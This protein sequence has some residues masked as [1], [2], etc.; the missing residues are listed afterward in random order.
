MFYHAGILGK[1]GPLGTVWI[2]GHSSKKVSKKKILSTKILVVC[3]DLET[4][5]G[6]FAL[7]VRASLL[8]GAT[9]ILQRQTTYL[10]HDA[11]DLRKKMANARS[12]KAHVINMK[13]KPKEK[14]KAVLTM[15]GA[16]ALS[17][18]ADW[19]HNAMFEEVMEEIEQDDLHTL[20]QNNMARPEDITLP[21]AI[22]V[23]DPIMEKFLEDQGKGPAFDEF[24][25]AYVDPFADDELDKL[26]KDAEQTLPDQS[27][28]LGGSNLDIPVDVP[29]QDLPAPVVIRQD[30]PGEKERGPEV[31]QAEGQQQPEVNVEDLTRHQ[32]GAMQ[33]PANRG[34]G[35]RGGRRRGPIVDLKTQISKDQMKLQLADKFIG[36]K[37]RE[38]PRQ[39]I[40]K[41]QQAH[42]EKLVY[43]TG[44]TSYGKFLQDVKH[45][46]F[47]DSAQVFKDLDRLSLEDDEDPFGWCAP[48]AP[49][50]DVP[51]NARAVLAPGVEP[52][53]VKSPERT[54]R[55]TEKRRTGGTTN[56]L[57]V[58]QLE[59]SADEP[60]FHQAN[61]TVGSEQPAAP[62]AV[63]QVSEEEVQEPAAKR[64]RRELRPDEKVEKLLE[65]ADYFE[66]RFEKFK[67]ATEVEE[68]SFEKIMDGNSR[69][70][71]ARCFTFMLQ[72]VKDGRIRVRQDAPYAPIMI[73]KIDPNMSLADP[74][75]LSRSGYQ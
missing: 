64:R 30:V 40:A 41:A 69:K 2:V 68:V 36:T 4:H 21:G 11:Q 14:M 6:K 53:A 73:Q 19:D 60:S 47:K 16:N 23:I 58:P 42:R 48:A 18:T 9:I 34:R 61:V 51:R 71:V 12:A 5:I 45:R 28:G 43:T 32:P 29:P 15:K 33:P 57:I 17:M 46:H 75:I 24:G 66:L 13:T 63:A 37:P 44:D 56:E 3:E 54:V 55:T 49:E 74:A 22:L 27:Q 50:P 31:V 65:A 8:L 10:L 70:K 35:R 26:R 20:L 1:T 38:D 72:L 67:Y 7:P 59:F 39:A 62:Q 25:G 52:E